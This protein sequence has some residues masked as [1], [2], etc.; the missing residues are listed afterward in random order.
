MFKK[1]KE[2]KKE[3]TK[4]RRVPKWLKVFN[5]LEFEEAIKVSITAYSSLIY[6]RYGK[7]MFWTK[8]LNKQKSYYKTF[9]IV[10]T[11][12]LQIVY[13]AA[14]YLKLNRLDWQKLCFD[15]YKTLFDKQDNS[16]LKFY[17]NGLGGNLA[18]EVYQDGICN[19]YG[20]MYTYF[21]NSFKGKMVKSLMDL[22]KA[23]SD[24]LLKRRNSIGKEAP[25]V[26]VKRTR[27]G[28]IEMDFTDGRA[29]N[30]WIDN[31]EKELR[32]TKKKILKNRHNKFI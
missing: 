13:K 24:A 26:K 9:F 31:S 11:N 19:T 2:F 12:L 8:Y 20:N 29:L 7:N 6:E 22:D 5:N 16:N 23:E 4:E 10:T 32:K 18:I 27:H 30:S 28:G 15:Y 3:E 14:P 25:G 1:E 21:E 17:L